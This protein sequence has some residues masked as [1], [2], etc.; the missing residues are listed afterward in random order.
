MLPLKSSKKNHWQLEV[1]VDNYFN[2]PTAFQ[3]NTSAPKID[4]SKIEALFNKYKERDSDNIDDA[5]ITQLT[6]DLGIDPED[7]V[8]MI[9]A[10][11]FHAKTPGVFTHKEFVEGL[12][13]LRCDTIDK[14]RDRLPALRA[15]ISEDTTF[16]NFYM[17]MYDY[18]RPPQQKSLALDVAIE[19]WKLLLGNRFKFINHWVDYLKENYKLAVSKDT[20]ALLLEFS[21]TINDGMT[22][23]D[24]DGAW[25]VLIDEFVA[26]YHENKNKKGDPMQS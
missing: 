13:T 5:G 18:G 23:Y 12:T 21:R 26:H 17:F 10:Y 25:P 1:A 9:L 24:S 20:W 19:L 14:L 22:N 16:R 2:N 7:I 6:T 15:E 8:M 11:H 3:D 4:T